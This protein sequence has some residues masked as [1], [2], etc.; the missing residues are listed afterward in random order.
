[1]SEAITSALGILTS[2]LNFVTGNAFL[3]V[4]IAVP[5]AIGVIGA[6]IHIFKR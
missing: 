1:M 2:C 4:L 5:L 3:V 6:L